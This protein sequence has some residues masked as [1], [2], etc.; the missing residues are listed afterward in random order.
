MT[1][2][3]GACGGRA[4][5][6]PA[7]AAAA[8]SPAAGVGTP[9][10]AAAQ[11]PPR[12]PARDSNEVRREA[13]AREVQEDAPTKPAPGASARALG[14]PAERIHFDFDRADIR[15]D[16]RP[17]LDAMIGWLRANP[18]VRLVIEGH[19]DER[20]ADEYN[21]ALGLRRAASVKRYWVAY[22]LDASRFETVSYG[23][24]R[25]LASGRDERSWSL[26][27]RAEFV[28]PEGL[29]VSVSR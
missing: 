10:P 5:P 17:V 21:L 26:N 28:L 13:V 9:A 19:C 18:R 20:G 11:V 8:A 2:V 22:G 12:Q 24:E 6:S 7:A 23:E 4:R 16:A 3:L 25:P 14:A 1:L 29:Q 15:E 27:R